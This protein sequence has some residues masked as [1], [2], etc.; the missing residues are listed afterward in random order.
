[1]VFYDSL[2]HSIHLSIRFAPFSRRRIGVI[3]EATVLPPSAC[4]NYYIDVLINSIN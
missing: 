4:L 1:M 2:P 3:L